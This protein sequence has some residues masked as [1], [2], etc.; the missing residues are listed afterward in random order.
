MPLCHSWQTYFNTTVMHTYAFLMFSCRWS[1]FFLTW[2]KIA[3]K[4]VKIKWREVW[5]PQSLLHG[6]TMTN[7]LTW[8][9]L[10]YPTTYADTIMRQGP[11][12]LKVHQKFPILVH[13]GWCDCLLAWWGTFRLMSM[14]TGQTFCL[15]HI[16]HYTIRI[17][18]PCIFKGLI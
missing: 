14:K 9:L 11:V 15:S 10:I 7:P 4:K 16:L 6:T 1:I 12:I 3:F 13:R 8:K 5:K 2:Y 18:A 17:P